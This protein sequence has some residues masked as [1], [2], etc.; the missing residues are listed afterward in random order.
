MNENNPR[1]DNGQLPFRGSV[2]LRTGSRCFAW[3]ALAVL[4]VTRVS[5]GSIFNIFEV[6]RKVYEEEYEDDGEDEPLEAYNFNPAQAF[7]TQKWANMT[8]AFDRLPLQG[9]YV[10]QS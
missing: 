3:F 2:H 7:V 8:T 10:Y 6:R 5:C 4:W 1:K 9:K